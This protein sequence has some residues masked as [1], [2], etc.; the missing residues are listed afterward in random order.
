MLNK[1]FYLK[2]TQ[3]LL[4]NPICIVGYTLASWKF[5]KD[6]ITFE[7]YYLIKFFGKSYIEYQKKVPSGVPFVKGFVIVEESLD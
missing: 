4:A 2:G 1:L 5:F 3:I 6:R 7:E